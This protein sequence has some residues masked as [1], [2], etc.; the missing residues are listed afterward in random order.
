MM[1]VTNGG[2]PGGGHSPFRPPGRTNSQGRASS[3]ACSWAPVT[4][5]TISRYAGRRASFAQERFWFLDQMDPGAALL[6]ESVSFRLTGVL[7]PAILRRSLQ[8]VVRRHEVLR[9]RF[10][11][12]DG[13]LFQ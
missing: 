13:Q 6:T 8:E 5:G 11:V 7:D 12:R 9:T 10:I 4:P 2:V 3:E 1:R